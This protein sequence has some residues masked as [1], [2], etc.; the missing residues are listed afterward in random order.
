MSAEFPAE[1]CPRR[2]SRPHSPSL[3]KN[4]RKIFFAFAS[5][6]RG[7][8][9]YFSRSSGCYRFNTLVHARFPC[10]KFFQQV[11]SGQK[12]KPKVGKISWKNISTDFPHFSV[13]F[14]ENSF[15]KCRCCTHLILDGGNL[16]I[17]YS[18]IKR[19]SDVDLDSFL[20]FFFHFGGSSTKRSAHGTFLHPFHLS[21]KS[22]GAYPTELSHQGG[23]QRTL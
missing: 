22:I 1:F 2:R 12:S 3:E 18:D 14:W 9:A 4:L 10:T 6:L 21:W 19:F 5:Q 13:D 17:A 20:F 8:T 11:R 23:V 7:G 16:Q 15:C